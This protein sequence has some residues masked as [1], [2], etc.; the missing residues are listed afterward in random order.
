MSL[1]QGP[2]LGDYITESIGYQLPD[3]A[4]YLGKTRD[5]VP[6][7]VAGFGN[8]RGYD[9]EVFLWSDGGLTRDF[10]RRIGEYAFREL[11]VKFVRCTV[12]ADQPDWLAQVERMGFRREGIERG[13]FD[14]QIDN[15]RLSVT[16][17]EFIL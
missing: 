2:L 11:R 16:A 3:P 15:I 7:C 5:G 10:L 8:Y 4:V 12:A 9:V 6:R 14:G 13:G 1:C 17:E